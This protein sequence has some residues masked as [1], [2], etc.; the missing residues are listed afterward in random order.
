MVSDLSD[1]KPLGNYV[2]DTVYHVCGNEY[3]NE[4]K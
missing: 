4:I 2:A 3:F 1:L